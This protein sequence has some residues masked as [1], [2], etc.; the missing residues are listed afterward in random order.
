MRR[1]REY[2]GHREI[3]PENQEA[4]EIWM[5]LHTLQEIHKIDDK[6][7]GT[8]H[9]NF[10]KHVPIQKWDVKRPQHSCHGPRVPKYRLK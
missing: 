5:S 2:C 10:F 6:I 8:R 4:S 7:S 3:L 1:K 9:D